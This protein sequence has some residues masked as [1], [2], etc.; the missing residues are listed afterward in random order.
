[1]GSGTANAERPPPGRADLLR[2]AGLAAAALVLAVGCAAWAASR[3][4]M[5]LSHF[6]VFYDGH[7]YI[8]IARSFPLPF[9]PAGRDYLGQAPGYPA[10]LALLRVVTPD[11]LDWGMLALLGAWLPA[12]LVP[13]AFYLLCRDTGVARP[14]VPAAI[15]ALAHPRWLLIA[16]TPRPEPLA[17]LLLVL[18]LGA[19]VRGRFGA[20][21]GLLAALVLT[22]FPAVLV[23]AAFALALLLTRRRRERSEWRALLLLAGVPALA[24][25]FY[26]GY[27]YWR[28]PDF[29][30]VWAAHQI[31]WDAR[32]TW[33]FQA[34]WTARNPGAWGDGNPLYP[35]TWGV[36]LVYAAAVAVGLRPAERR[37]WVLP[38]CVVALVLFH[39]SLSGIIGAWDFTRL[40][41]LA[42]PPAVLACW[43][44]AERRVPALLAVAA[45]GALAVWGTAFTARQT[46]SAVAMQTR[47]QPFVTEARHRLDA[48]TPHWV[49]F[50]PPP[51]RPGRHPAR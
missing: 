25:A 13:P 2:M 15:L 40:T 7:L 41:I 5:P 12:A 17:V 14:W 1:V 33:P 36:L 48:D 10:L 24:F 50:S 30:G 16:A 34:L 51:E 38:I 8:E 32:I 31:F 6:G 37:L 45:T 22:R 43:R 27:L 19:Y 23:V 3:N 26:Q 39:A 28:I 18:A 29:R 21:G 44:A 4:G 42:W 49:R 46:A 20:A 9:S 35:V 11:A 47:T